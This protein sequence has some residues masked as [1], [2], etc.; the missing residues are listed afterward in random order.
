LVLV[1]TAAGVAG[2]VYAGELVG[3]GVTVV[4]VTGLVLLLPALPPLL[5]NAIVASPVSRRGAAAAVVAVAALL[6]AV[7]AVPAGL[8]VVDDGGVPGSQTVEIRDY[9]VGYGENVTAQRDTLVDF[10]NETDPANA[11]GVI[12]TSTER[13]IW[14]VPIRQQSLAFAGND[15]VVV[16]GVGW[17][18]SVAVNR[19]GWTVV[20]NDSVYAV[21]LTHA[22]EV[23]RSY[24]SP[25]STADVRVDG[26]EVGVAPT[27]DG[28]ELRVIENE[29]TVGTAP[30][31]AV[32]GSTTVA[33]LRLE[34][35]PGEDTQRVV[36]VSDG[37]EVQ[38]AA[39]ETYD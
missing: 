20:G 37:T 31:P 3:L 6:I 1:T 21:D 10:G 13:Q 11:S 27:P 14:A 17:R 29:T 22:G 30:I 15:T 7:P 18:E 34:V 23:T 36:A 4:V 8:V 26:Y 32:N 19:T 5:P 39:R 24:R 38:V 35:R 9:E 28:F 12:L 2:I 33:D 16:G 25:P